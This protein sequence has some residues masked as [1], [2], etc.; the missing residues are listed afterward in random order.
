MVIENYVSTSRVRFFIEFNLHLFVKQ[1]SG[2]Y[3]QRL[4]SLLLLSQFAFVHT[5]LTASRIL[6]SNECFFIQTPGR[7]SFMQC[8]IA[9]I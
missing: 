8:A 3:D 4:S 1:K 7:G 9:I 2:D 6:I 5:A